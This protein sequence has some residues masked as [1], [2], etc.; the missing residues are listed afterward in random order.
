ME[1]RGCSKNIFVSVFVNCKNLKW[2]ATPAFWKNV[3]YLF[4]GASATN[5]RN[6]ADAFSLIISY[7]RIMLVL[8]RV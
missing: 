8:K 6:K 7:L 2:M 1:G 4:F 5:L 3:M